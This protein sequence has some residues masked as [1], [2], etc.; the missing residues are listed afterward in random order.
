[1]TS[2]T[3]Q[4]FLEDLVFFIPKC[5]V[6]ADVLMSVTVAANA[7][8]GGCFCHRLAT[9]NKQFKDQ[10]YGDKVDLY[11]GG[12]FGFHFRWDI[13]F[14]SRCGNTSRIVGDFQ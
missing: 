14:E 11:R 3:E 6:G 7:V 9:T 2:D 4:S 13:Q 8:S 5:K 10:R 1:V 12:P